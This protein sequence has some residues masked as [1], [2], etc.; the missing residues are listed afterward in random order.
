MFAQLEK[1]NHRPKAYEFYT[2]QDLWDDEYVSQKMLELH[3]NPEVDLASRKRAFIGTSSQWIASRFQLGSGK[4]VCDFGCGPGLYA[5]R[6]AK[7]GAKV[8]GLDFSR[9]SIAHAR[10]QALKQGLAI[11]Y[12]LGNYL[13]FRSEK[14]I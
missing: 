3:L 9:N 12:C 8:T 11:D 4:R 1:I 5:E 14:K 6:F 7:T 13:E 2:A 10:K